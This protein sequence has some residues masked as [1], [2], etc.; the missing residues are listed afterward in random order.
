MQGNFLQRKGLRCDYR[1]FK[2]HFLSLF[3]LLFT[4]RNQSEG[5]NTV[6]LYHC[7]LLSAVANVETLTT[8]KNMC[9][10]PLTKLCVSMYE[11]FTVVNIYHNQSV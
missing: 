5:T 4:E 3:S 1:Q 2:L 9:S 6:K 10:L 11:H 8:T 7:R